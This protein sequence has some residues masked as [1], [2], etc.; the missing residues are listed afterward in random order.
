MRG[1]GERRGDGTF[2]SL[3]VNVTLAHLYRFDILPG[4][5]YVLGGKVTKLDDGRTTVMHV[6]NSIEHRALP[7]GEVVEPGPIMISG[8]GVIMRVRY[9]NTK[10]VENPT[11]EV[12]VSHDPSGNGDGRVKVRWLLAMGDMDIPYNTN[13]KLGTRIALAGRLEALGEPA[14]LVVV[15][16][17]RGVYYEECKEG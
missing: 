8:T 2:D 9:T 1:Q 6:D 5:S 4:H 7:G 12:L 15:K 17:T 3:P 11:L 16:A 14:G 10:H 13:F